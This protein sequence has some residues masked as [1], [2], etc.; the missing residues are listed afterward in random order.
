MQTA[1]TTFG[2]APPG[3]RLPESTRIGRVRLQVSDLGRSIS[4]YE[5]VLGLRVL[6]TS[7]GSATMGGADGRSL[8]SLQELP[9]ARPVPRR[10]LLGLYHFAVLLPDR[11]SLGK[12]AAHLSEIGVRAGMSDHLVSEAIYLNDPDGLGIEVYAD[13]ART[14]WTGVNRQ[15]AM[16]TKPL[17]VGDLIRSAA[18]GKW[19]GAPA[20][21]IIGHVHFHIEDID[22]AAEFYHAA[23]GM[24]KMVW[25]YP[26]ALF[27]AA[28]GYHHHVGLNT[29]AAG[30]PVATDNDA[31][32]LEWELLLPDEDTI[33]AALRSIE[34]AGFTVENRDGSATATDPW[35]IKVRLESA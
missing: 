33:H 19:D 3:Y 28:G 31:R 34:A 10:G 29:W 8:L 5:Q 1:A 4:Y 24:D 15:I 11:A 23:L 22:R 7:S 21:T 30:A 27:V 18:G 35:N 13:R 32:L 17:D 26:G 6:E 25:S 14:T 2:I 9:G 20:G 16:T 12:F